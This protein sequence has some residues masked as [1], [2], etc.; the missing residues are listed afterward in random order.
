[1]PGKHLFEYAVIRLVPR[2]E[3]EEFINIGVILYC[4][5][6]KFLDLNY[7]LNEE[8]LKVFCR[9]TNL[10]ELRTRLRGFEK[11]CTGDNDGGPIAKLPIASRFRWLAASRS[12]II[13][14]SDIHPG[15]CV[16]ATET[17]NKLMIQ[18]VL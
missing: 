15:L 1:M 12:T 5:S 6:F 4:A 8:K 2:V 18:L 17:L 9:D 3:R 7:H 10:R 13:Q 16:D 11:I 14:T